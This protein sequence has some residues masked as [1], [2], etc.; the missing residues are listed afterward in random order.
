METGYKA[1]A[2]TRGRDNS[3]Q[4]WAAAVLMIRSVKI[5]AMI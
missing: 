5:L 2:I 4:T 3:S 1:I